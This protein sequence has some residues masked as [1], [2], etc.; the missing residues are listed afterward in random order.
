[1]LAAERQ[2]EILK[3]IK[4]SGIVRTNDLARAFSCTEETVRRDLDKLTN[5]NLLIRTHGGAVNLEEHTQD[6][7]HHKREGRQVAEKDAIGKLATEYIRPG[8]SIIVDESSTVLSFIEHLPKDIPLKIIT[9][10]LL[11]P[12]RMNISDQHELIQLGGLY[13]SKSKS[14]HGILSEIALERLHIDKFFFSCK[15]LDPHKGASEPNEQRA[16]MKYN[17]FKN[18]EWSCALA[19]H[20]KMG[21]KSQYFFAD[22]AGI[23]LI[24]SDAGNPDHGLEDFNKLG[25]E[26]VVADVKAN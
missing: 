6:L 14:Y 9:Y 2:Q 17:I 11:V 22:T 8:D 5:Q 25:Q 7:H 15:G 23:D 16:R 21:V 19:D 26:I 24:I 20:S 3:K 18:A 10:S 13:D 4:N 12:Q 1:M